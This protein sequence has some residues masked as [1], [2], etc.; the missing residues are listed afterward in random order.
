[1]AVLLMDSALLSSLLSWAIG[2]ITYENPEILV[3]DLKL[4]KRKD[5][6]KT[7]R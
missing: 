6:V 7:R 5:I 4:N 3:K 1:M 2:Q